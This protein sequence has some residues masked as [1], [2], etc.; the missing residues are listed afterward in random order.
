MKN[1]KRIKNQ[2]LE[3]N[4][5]ENS[6]N[7]SVNG[8]NAI[9]IGKV[10]NANGSNSDRQEERRV[11]EPAHDVENHIP[12]DENKSLPRPRMLTT[13][14]DPH[15]PDRPGRPSVPTPGKYG[16]QYGGAPSPGP[17]PL[18]LGGGRAHRHA[19][20]PAVARAGVVEVCLQKSGRKYSD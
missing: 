1:Q 17:A 4:H 10:S 11:S 13:P 12:E 18:L 14:D 3:N 19:A 9:G 7:M 8:S 15:T 6:E 20:W 5:R 2:E 16:T